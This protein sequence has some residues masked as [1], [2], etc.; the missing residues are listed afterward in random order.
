[1]KKWELSLYSITNRKL[2]LLKLA[3]LLILVC[4]YSSSTL[5]FAHSPTTSSLQMNSSIQK[6]DIVIGAWAPSNFHLERM[7]DPK[8]VNKAILNLL[9][10]GFSEYYFVM[11]DFNNASEVKATE[12]LLKAADKTDLK[13]VVILL[14]P[15]ESGNYGAY[16]NA[17]YHWKGWIDYFNSLKRL[18]P[19]SFLGFAIDDFNAVDG[20]RRLYVRNN[21]NYFMDSSNL[22]VALYSKRSDIQF[23]PVMYL[24]TGGFETLKSNYDKLLSGI[25]LVNISP[26]SSSSSSYNLLQLDDN[27]KALSKMFENKPLKYILYPTTRAQAQN[28]TLSDRHIMNTLSKASRL[29][30]YIIIYVRTDDSTIQYFLHNSPHFKS[31]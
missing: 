3:A 9:Q 28:D 24:E 13:I 21:I 6:K 25:I 7:Q 27:T 18:H 15:S 2:I 1:L 10:Q 31:R 8:Q 26:M 16:S 20:I 17:N 29:F 23:Y 5:C 14:P 19:I 22:S 12:Q 30:D 11:R 4:F